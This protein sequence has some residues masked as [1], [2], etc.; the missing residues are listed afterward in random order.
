MDEQTIEGSHSF[1]IGEAVR[2]GSIEKAIILKEITRMAAYKIR[3]KRDNIWVYYSASALAEKFPYMNSKSI[4]RWMQELVEEGELMTTVDNKMKYDKTKSYIPTQFS[5]FVNQK[6]QQVAQF[7]Q[8]VAPDEQPIPPLSTPLSTPLSLASPKKKETFEEFMAEKNYEPY[9]FED[10]EGTIHS[11]FISLE[12]SVLSVGKLK[13][14]RLEYDKKFKVT[15]IEDWLHVKP[16]SPI[17]QVFRVFNNPASVQ[18]V[19]NKTQ[20]K[21]AE[22]LLKIMSVNDM[23]IVMEYVDQNRQDEYFPKVTSPYELLNK[24]SALKDKMSKKKKVFVGTV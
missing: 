3:T 18:W 21:A 17:D 22:E 5:E 24:L 14:Y 9:D 12:G 6:E 15:G 20:R 19:A 11:T 1:Q 10:G 2:L 4:Q 7:D 23:K 8:Q 16:V 13:N